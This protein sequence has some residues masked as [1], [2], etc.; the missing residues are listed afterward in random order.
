MTTTQRIL[1]TLNTNT[2]ILTTSV[3]DKEALESVRVSMESSCMAAPV[4]AVC[5][6]LW[7]WVVRLEQVVPVLPRMLDLVLR[8]HLRPHTSLMVRKMLG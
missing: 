2:N 5:K 7:A 1:I 3:L 8:L 6:G 4:R